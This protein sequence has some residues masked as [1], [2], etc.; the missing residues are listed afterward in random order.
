MYGI[1][2]Y[3][4]NHGPWASY[5]EA[6]GLHRSLP[7]FQKAEVDGIIMRNPKKYTAIISLNRPTILVV[8][9]EA[10]ESDFPRVITCGQTIGRMAAEHFLDRGFQDFGF[11]G[12]DAMFWSRERE[13][14]FS[15]HLGEAG[16]TAHTYRQSRYKT[17]R[18]WEKEKV[19]LSTRKS[20]VLK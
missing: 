19:H 10:E 7:H 16:Y 4:R 2:R 12:Y 14:F 3:S 8:H 6:G 13:R 5:K 1:A 17:A 9:Q 11:C 18:A 15:R 20:N